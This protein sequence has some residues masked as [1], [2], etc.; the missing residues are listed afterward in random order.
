MTAGLVPYYRCAASAGRAEAARESGMSEDG[1]S[2]YSLPQNNC[3]EVVQLIIHS[4]SLIFTMNLL[5]I[6]LKI[7]SVG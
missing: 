2:L 5:R 1:V 3:S 6:H 7:G 4:F